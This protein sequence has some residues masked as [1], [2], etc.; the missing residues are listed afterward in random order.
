MQRVCAKPAGVHGKD[1]LRCEAEENC[2][3]VHEGSHRE[4]SV[5]RNSERLL[6]LQTFTIEYEN[7]D[8]W[9]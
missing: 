7:K 6:Q 4:R 1:G 8:T 3:G 2:R 5:P 9:C